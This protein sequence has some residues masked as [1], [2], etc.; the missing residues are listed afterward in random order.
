MNGGLGMGNQVGPEDGGWW[1]VEIGGALAHAQYERA[2][3]GA[4]T[5]A[6]WRISSLT[7]EGAD[8][9]THVGK[10]KCEFGFRVAS[11]FSPSGS[12]HRANLG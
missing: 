6:W 10:G 8:V 9:E 4:A 1:G 12:W 3:G 11:R 2:R 7:E 5:H